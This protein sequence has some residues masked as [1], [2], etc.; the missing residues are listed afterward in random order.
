[1]NCI[2]QSN[3]TPFDFSKKEILR[4]MVTKFKIG[5]YYVNMR[6]APIFY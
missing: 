2:V 3:F 6:V 5:D 1:M 4:A